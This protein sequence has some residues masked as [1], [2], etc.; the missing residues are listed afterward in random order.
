MIKPLVKIVGECRFCTKGNE[1]DRHVEKIIRDGKSEYR[2]GVG[3]PCIIVKLY[4]FVD[5]ASGFKDSTGFY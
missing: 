2:C 5:E 4:G 1:S 3:Q